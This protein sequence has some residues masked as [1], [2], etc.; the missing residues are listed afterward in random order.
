MDRHY[1]GQGKEGFTVGF[2]IQDERMANALLLLLSIGYRYRLP[3]VF[4]LWVVLISG[5]ILL[6][7]L[8]PNPVSDL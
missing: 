6:A 3:L 1:L 5:H 2:P 4:P 8:N 7:N